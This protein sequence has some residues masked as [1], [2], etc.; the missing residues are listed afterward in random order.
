GHCRAGQADRRWVEGAR[1]PIAFRR[2]LV[3]NPHFAGVVAVS[4]VAFH[5]VTANWRIIAVTVIPAGVSARS[6][7][8]TRADPDGNAQT[9]FRTGM[10]FLAGRSKSAGQRQ[11]RDGNGSNFRTDGHS[12]LPWHQRAI[13][14]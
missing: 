8:R 9:E 14:G 11:S 5:P 2:R 6:K 10:S 13:R 12:Y 3:A 7:Q 4:A 1:A